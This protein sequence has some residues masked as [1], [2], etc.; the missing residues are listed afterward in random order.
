M[1]DI[2][3]LPEELRKKE[4][5]E[6]KEAQKRPSVF[7]VKFTAPQGAEKPEHAGKTGIFSSVF[8]K[9]EKPLPYPKSPPMEGI[10]PKKQQAQTKEEIPVAEKKPVIEKIQ[11]AKLEEIHIAPPEKKEILP[12][13]PTIV[14]PAKKPMGFWAWI[15]SLFVKQK[16]EKIPMPI[17]EKKPILPP[18]AKFEPERKLE[19]RKEIIPASIPPR[20]PLPIPLKPTL[21]KP[22]E[23]LKPTP[24]APLKTGK[25][26]AQKAMPR[27]AGKEREVEIPVKT[28][29]IN[30]IPQDLVQHPELY[31]GKKIILLFIA[32]FVSAAFVFGWYEFIQWRSRDIADQN[33][34]IQAEIDTIKTEM[35]QYDRER[36]EVE[37]LIAGLSSMEDLLNR[38]VYWTRVFEQLQNYT[39]DDVYFTN[40][41]ASRDGTLRLS[42]IGR[43]Y[44]SVAR[45]LVV[46]QNARNF[47]SKVEINS[48]SARTDKDSEGKPVI[49][50]TSFDVMIELVPEIFYAKYK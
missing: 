43:D 11:P 41:A 15:K 6:K 17:L 32:A 1:V 7:E 13:K 20:P 21:Q 3:L 40:F 30:L 29:A 28:L 5:Q 36:K 50:G 37:A 38:H 33:N 44:I 26:E 12:K 22:P 25:V 23:P 2:N 46:F 31:I 16:K 9:K 10:V 4:E 39:I 42:A 8:Q 27:K 14:P 35:L 24:P 49:T 45:Q 19:E 34:K 47:V 48:A 18:I